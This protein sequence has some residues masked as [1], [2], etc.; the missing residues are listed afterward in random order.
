MVSQRPMPEGCGLSR[1]DCKVDWPLRADV[2]YCQRCYALM[3]LQKQSPAEYWWEQ[4]ANERATVVEFSCR[5]CGLVRSAP[6][7]ENARNP[8]VWARR[9]AITVSSLLLSSAKTFLIVVAVAVQREKLQLASRHSAQGNRAIAR[10]GGTHMHMNFKLSPLH[11]PL[12]L[13][14]ST[15]FWRTGRSCTAEAHTNLPQYQYITSVAHTH[16]PAT[17]A[18]LH[19]YCGQPSDFQSPGKT[20][21]TWHAEVQVVLHEQEC[22]SNH[23]AA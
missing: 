21:F 12:P 23:H 8:A 6:L 9:V 15:Q 1:R 20:L 14:G 4:C 13:G 19:T 11:P 10:R 18:N 16:C 7:R 5:S 3:V 2:A 17:P 22:F